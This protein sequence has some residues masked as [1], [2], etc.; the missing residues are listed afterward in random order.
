MLSRLVI[1]FLPRLQSPSAVILEDRV[2]DSFS[3]GPSLGY[4][5]QKMFPAAKSE[6]RW[7]LYSSLNRRVGFWVAKPRNIY[8]QKHFMDKYILISVFGS[9][10]VAKLCLTPLQPHGIDPARLFCPWDFSGKTTRVDCHFLLQ[11]IFPTQGV[12]LCFLLDRQ[13]LY[14]WATWETP[15]SY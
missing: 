7:V 11:G 15:N 8:L 9:G 2:V 6:L 14:Y 1:T 13:I 12:N 4:K 10:L 5:V 3:S